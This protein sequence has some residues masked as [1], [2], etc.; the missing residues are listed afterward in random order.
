[1][2][3]F[4]LSYLKLSDLLVGRSYKVIYRVI[5]YVCVISKFGRILILIL[6]VPGRGLPFTAVKT[7]SFQQTQTSTT[8]LCNMPYI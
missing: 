2:I 3:S 7:R 4:G 6:L 5:K 1:M 8:L